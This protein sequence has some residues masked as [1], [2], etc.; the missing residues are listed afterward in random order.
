MRSICIGLYLDSESASL[1]ATLEALRGNTSMPFDL[2]LLPDGTD[3][4]TRRRLTQ[5]GDIAQSAT[6][7]ARGAAACFNR[8]ANFNQAEILVL[9]ESGARVGPGWL[10]HLLAALDQDE[11][12][13]LAGPS[14]NRSWNEQQ[15][16][17]R[18][19][20]SLAEI[21]RTA[22][23]AIEMFGAEAR[24]LSPLYSLADFCYV[25]RREVLEA[26]GAADENYGSGPCW[27]MDFNI[28]AA[29]AGFRGVWAGAAFVHR[30]PFTRRRKSA[31]ARLMDAS[32]R[33]YQNKFCGA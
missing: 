18:C 21:A 4:G 6:A 22:V 2:V 32:K 9:L 17:P 16:F 7:E 28:R 10:E 30:Q 3:A 8:L 5:F 25:V 12:N 29:R 15:V 27:E 19:G 24:E 11:R 1:P 13:G 26:L 23:A 31:E 33:L 14:T 20:S